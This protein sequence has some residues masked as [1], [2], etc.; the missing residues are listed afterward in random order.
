MAYI[1]TKKKIMAY[2]AQLAV[3]SHFKVFKDELISS[4]HL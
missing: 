1:S 4:S 3:N 2:I